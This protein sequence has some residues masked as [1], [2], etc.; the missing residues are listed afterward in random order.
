MVCTC[1]DDPQ[2][3]VA[4]AYENMAPGGWIEFQDFFCDT[5]HEYNKGSPLA[6][7]YDAVA[8]GAEIRGRDLKQPLKYQKWLEEAGCK[9][10]GYL[11]GHDVLTVLI[12]FSC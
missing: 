6:K 10:F 7:W 12:L 5:Q 4:Q 9:L 8:K 1:F 2:G 11:A 3:V